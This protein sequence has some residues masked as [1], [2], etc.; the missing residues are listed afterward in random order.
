M[1]IT[2]ITAGEVTRFWPFCAPADLADRKGVR[3]KCCGENY[4]DIECPACEDLLPIETRCFEIAE[5]LES[6]KFTCPTCDHI[7]I[8]EIEVDYDEETRH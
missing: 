4:G 6:L 2:E 1:P 8:C 3:G 7:K 5:G